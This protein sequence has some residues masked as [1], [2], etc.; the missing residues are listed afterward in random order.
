MHHKHGIRQNV[1]AV[2]CRGRG[3]KSLGGV[4]SRPRPQSGTRD[5]KILKISEK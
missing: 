5:V 4:C 1:K 3:L 2:C